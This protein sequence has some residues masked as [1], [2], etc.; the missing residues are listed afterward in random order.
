MIVLKQC[1]TGGEYG[2]D[3]ST[4]PGS[5]YECG[6]SDDDPLGSE[7]GLP[8]LTDEAGTGILSEDDVDRQTGK[9]KPSEVS[10][11]EEQEPERE[12][13]WVL[14]DHPAI[15]TK[16]MLRALNDKI[17]EL[18]NIQVCGKPG[19]VDY[20]THKL[21]DAYRHARERLLEKWVETERNRCEGC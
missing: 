12:G 9:P 5:E 19:G 6:E 10:G 17:I 13:E 21:K 16:E 4:N 8:L 18:E 7:Q 2:D 14:W 3:I 1:L 20:R 15:M 11:E